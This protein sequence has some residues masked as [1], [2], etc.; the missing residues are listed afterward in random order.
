MAAAQ[1]AC[2]GTCAFQEGGNVADKARVAAAFET[3]RTVFD[4]GVDVNARS[5]S[6]QTAM[7]I[8]AFTGSNPVVQFLA[9]HGA[10]LN[11]RDNNGETP[12]S[13]ASGL[14]T[15]LGQRGLYGNHKSTADLLLK[16]GAEVITMQELE[17]YAPPYSGL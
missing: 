7:H 3:V 5:K 2:T 1:V 4:M 11:I 16:L 6:G 14:T 17:E 10:V 9:E 15:R 13:M 12:W 8:A